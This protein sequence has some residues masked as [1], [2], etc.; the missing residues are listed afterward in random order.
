MAE[1][2]P[3]FPAYQIDLG[4][5]SC[6]Y[7]NQLGLEGKTAESLEWFNRAIQSREIVRKKVRSDMTAKTSRCS[8]RDWQKRNKPC[9]LRR[10]VGIVLLVPS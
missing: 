6:N 9:R 10:R 5:S 3:D 1:Q 2:F 4:G 7:G 8:W